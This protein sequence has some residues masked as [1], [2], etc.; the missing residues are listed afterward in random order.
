MGTLGLLAN[1]A[2]RFAL[3]SQ[4]AKCATYMFSGSRVSSLDMNYHIEIIT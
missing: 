4:K 1:L 3:Q 2:P